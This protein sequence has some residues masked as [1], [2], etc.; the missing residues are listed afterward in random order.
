MDYNNLGNNA[1]PITDDGDAI[2]DAFYREMGNRAD[3]YI[4]E[5]R[6]KFT[7]ELEIKMRRELAAKASNGAAQAKHIT[8]I[9]ALEWA[10]KQL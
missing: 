8:W 10:I 4:E 5:N 7:L 9:E 1:E 2:D 6:Y 3:Q